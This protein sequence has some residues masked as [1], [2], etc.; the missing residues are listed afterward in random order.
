MSEYALCSNLSSYMSAAHL[1]SLNTLFLW[2]KEQMELMQSGKKVIL[3]AKFG[4]GKTLI[5]KSKALQLAASLKEQE[6]APKVFFVTFTAADEER[7]SPFC[8]FF[9]DCITFI[10][11]WSDFE[12]T[13][14]ALCPVGWVDFSVE[15][16]KS[17]L[18]FLYC[19][20]NKRS[21]W[22]IFPGWHI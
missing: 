22:L 8:L 3:D 9:K 19:K 21:F 6:D 14:W 16:F 7:V 13:N 20:Y 18:R 4:H 15:A 1:G 17:C 11:G 5:L 2:S 12:D 10:L